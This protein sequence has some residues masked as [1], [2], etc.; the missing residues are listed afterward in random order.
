M[1]ATSTARR[2]IRNAAQE[3]NK[4]N[5]YNKITTIKLSRNY[6][7]LKKVNTQRQLGSGKEKITSKYIT[8]K[9]TAY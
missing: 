1:C 5:K 7:T 9:P 6:M 3:Q 8:V 2:P 4:N